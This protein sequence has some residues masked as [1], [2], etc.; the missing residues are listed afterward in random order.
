LTGSLPT[1]SIPAAPL[2]L[3]EL[4]LDWLSFLPNN[5]IE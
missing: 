2:F 3:N 5:R 4:L 1:G